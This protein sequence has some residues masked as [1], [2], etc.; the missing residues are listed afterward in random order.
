MNKQLINILTKVDNDNHN[1][2]IIHIVTK[3]DNI[4]HILVKVD[5]MI[6]NCYDDIKYGDNGIS[7]IDEDENA[8]LL[9]YKYIV[10]V[11]VRD[12]Y[13]VT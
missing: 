9:E 13:N 2:N 5:N 7:F 3:V 10:G 12:I 6:Y 4:I 11:K 1:D 8:V